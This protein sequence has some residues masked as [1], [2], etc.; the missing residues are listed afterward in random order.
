MVSNLENTIKSKLCNGI[1][2]METSL[3][4]DI[5]K[6]INKKPGGLYTGAEINL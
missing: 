2:K 5:Y 3:G 6:S 4:W 1:F